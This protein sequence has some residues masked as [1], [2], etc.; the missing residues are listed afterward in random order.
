MEN[1]GK[2][3]CKCTYACKVWRNESSP[4]AQK[5]NGNEISGCLD[6]VKQNLWHSY[7]TDLAAE[8]KQD[9]TRNR[10]T[11]GSK[12]GAKGAGNEKVSCGDWGL[13]RVKMYHG[14]FSVADANW[15]RSY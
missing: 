12:K 6:G 11:N 13:R 3:S 15:R 8:T 5:G 9:K 7:D 1:R 2:D 14:P 10:E 4:K